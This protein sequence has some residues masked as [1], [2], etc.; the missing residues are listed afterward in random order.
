[1]A[2]GVVHIPW[3]ATFFRAERFAEALAEIAP[4]AL[5]YGATEYSVQQSR[6][7]KYHFDHQVAFDDKL[8]WERFWNG[9]EMISFREEYSS[10]YQ[11]PV[12]YVWHTVVAHGRAELTE[13]NGAATPEPD[14]EPEPAEA[15]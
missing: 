10:W 13:V 5:R 3:Y 6:D 12:L 8:S 7:D 14:P 11:V 15:A 9:P 4:V 1:M 2:A